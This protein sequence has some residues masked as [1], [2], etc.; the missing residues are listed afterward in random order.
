MEQS[1]LSRNQSLNEKQLRNAI[2]LLGG[3][4]V[5]EIRKVDRKSS[6]V[7][8]FIRKKLIVDKLPAE[9]IRDNNNNP[10]LWGAGFRNICRQSSNG[11]FGTFRFTVVHKARDTFGANARSRHCTL[12]QSA[13][14][15]RK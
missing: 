12:S 15:I 14:A 8:I 4:T 13:L 3:D 7:S 11:A 9:C 2:V 6:S 10:F 5:H 1:F